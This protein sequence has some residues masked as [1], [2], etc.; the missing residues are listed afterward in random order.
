MVGYSLGSLGRQFQR[1]DEAALGQLDRVFVSEVI[2]IFE[3]S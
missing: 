1:V 3:V 2:D